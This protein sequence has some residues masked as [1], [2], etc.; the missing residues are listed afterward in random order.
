MTT[1]IAELL[2]RC[3]SIPGKI[4][5]ARL[6]AE[7]VTYGNLYRHT[8]GAVAFLRSLG[9]KA[10]DAVVLATTKNWGFIYGYLALHA[11][12]AVAVPL[13]PNSSESAVAH[14]RE[15]SGAVTVFWPDA[16]H[17]QHDTSE[18]DSVPPDDAAIAIAARPENL[19]DLMFTSGSTGEAKAVCITHANIA[20][21]ICN[22]NMFVGNTASDVEVNPMPL[23]HAFGMGRMRCTLAQGAT[24]VAVDGMTRPK[25]L[26]QT[27]SDFHATGLCMVVAAWAMLCRLSG[28]RISVFKNQLRYFE[29][30]SAPLSKNEKIVAIQ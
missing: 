30:G 10:G 22:M 26:F 16:A 29:L 15:V 18:L 5:L 17:G 9:I 25:L 3:Q 7:P 4:A 8:S 11:L 19:A 13:N 24:M 23:S 20:A 1:F 27:I 28:D 21:S 14:A 2:A 12:G 6:D